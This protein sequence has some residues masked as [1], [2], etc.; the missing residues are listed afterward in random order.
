MPKKRFLLICRRQLVITSYSQEAYESSFH[1]R[2]RS[3]IYDSR[4]TLP[5]GRY[6][7]ERIIP[8]W[9]NPQRKRCLVIKGTKNGLPE[10]YLRRNADTLGVTIKEIAPR[11]TASKSRP[12]RRA[13]KK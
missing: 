12:Q 11:K 1:R 10:T 6:E 8:K 9:D 13:N 3:G 7:A 2:N 5:I 4:V